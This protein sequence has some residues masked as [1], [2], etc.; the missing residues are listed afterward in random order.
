[1]ISIPLFC[2]YRQSPTQ[3]L[4]VDVSFYITA[5]FILHY[6]VIPHPSPGAT[7]WLLKAAAAPLCPCAGPAKT[8]PPYLDGHRSIRARQSTP[9]KGPCCQTTCWTP[10]RY[11]KPVSSKVFGSAF[12]IHFCSSGHAGGCIA[13]NKMLLSLAHLGASVPALIYCISA[14]IDTK[15]RM[16]YKQCR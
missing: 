10:E 5:S 6:R 13:S 3:E 2:K 15:T 16:K 8:P 14:E 12:L 7:R 9:A 11:N 1:M 4:T